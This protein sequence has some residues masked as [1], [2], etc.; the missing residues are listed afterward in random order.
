MT[1]LWSGYRYNTI[2][3]QE[4]GYS[5]EPFEWTAY[6]WAHN[7]D[8]GLFV[9][10]PKEMAGA[11]SDPAYPPTDFFQANV[12]G[13]VSADGPCWLPVFPC[14]DVLFRCVP[15]LLQDLA[16]PD[17]LK[18]TAQGQQAVQFLTD[19]KKFWKVIPVGAGASVVIAL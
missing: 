1:F 12:K 11:P 7:E 5:F 8:E 13:W 19:V 15:L 4:T 3:L 2:T 17:K 9:C 14:K 16:N 18:E 10:M 6:S